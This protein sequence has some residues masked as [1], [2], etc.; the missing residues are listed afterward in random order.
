MFEPNGRT[1]FA[2]DTQH[3]CVSNELGKI[4]G[5]MRV[6]LLGEHG[7]WLAFDAEQPRE[8][9]R[10][11]HLSCSQYREDPTGNLVAMKLTKGCG[12]WKKS[13]ELISYFPSGVDLGWHGGKVWLLALKFGTSKAT[14]GVAHTLNS[15]NPHTLEVESTIEV[16][17]PTGGVNLLETCPSTSL[18]LVSW[19]DQSEWGYVVVDLALGLQTLMQMSWKSPTT[20]PPRLSPGGLVAVSCHFERAAWWN[21]ESDD[22]SEVPSP[23]G[24]RRIGTITSHDLVPTHSYTA[25]FL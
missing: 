25:R 24:L 20:A 19:L 5:H 2:D 10:A 4:L 17:V 6:V 1:S 22:P 11:K 7:A 3:A 14:S 12:I 23:G 8:L 16:V 9:A 15:L 18:A 13:G 21:D